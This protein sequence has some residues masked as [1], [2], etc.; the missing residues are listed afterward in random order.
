MKVRGQAAIEGSVII[1]LDESEMRALDALVG[2]GTDAF[3]KA[4]YEKMGQSYLKPHEHGLRSFFQVVEQEVRPHL[5]R[6]NRA[7]A[8]FEGRG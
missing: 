4:F 1:V 5:G 2:Y 3:L 6:I 8:V 7:R